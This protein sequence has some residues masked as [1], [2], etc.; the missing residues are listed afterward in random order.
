MTI[1]VNQSLEVSCPEGF[2]V[3][4]AEERSKIS[5]YGGGECECL[6]DPDRHMVVCIGWKPLPALAA[7]MLGAADAAKDMEKKVRKPMQPFGY[8]FLRNEKT[9]LDG[10]ATHGFAYEYNAQGTAMVGESFACRKSKTMY[11]LHVYYRK[12]LETES[13]PVWKEILASMKWTG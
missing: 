10:E 1:T 5:F 11:Y 6:S 13:A 7:L 8:T 12:E 4:D 9:S 2:H 3:M